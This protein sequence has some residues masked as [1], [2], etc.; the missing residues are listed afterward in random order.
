M[1]GDCRVCIPA[2]LE[3]ELVRGVVSELSS[4]VWHAAL[5]A[6]RVMIREGRPGGFSP[7]VSGS[8]FITIVYVKR[9]VLRSHLSN[10]TLIQGQL[11]VKVCRIFMV[12]EKVFS[13]CAWALRFSNS[14]IRP[15]YSTPIP[16]LELHHPHSFM[17][18]ERRTYHHSSS[19]LGH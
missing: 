13:P 11:Q 4:L 14:S 6:Q 7:M 9:K 19:D 5:S 15:A 8:R 1:F 17:T 2:K 3:Q 10:Y 16:P 18:K 12:R